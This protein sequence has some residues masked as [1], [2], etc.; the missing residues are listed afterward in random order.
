MRKHLECCGCVV[1]LVDHAFTCMQCGLVHG[2]EETHAYLD[3]NENKHKIVR[4]SVYHRKY[5][6][7]NIIG[8]ICV[9]NPDL[10]IWRGQINKILEVFPEIEKVVPIVNGRRMRIIRLF[11]RLVLSIHHV[12]GLN[13]AHFHCQT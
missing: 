4:K 10:Q 2:Y 6:I 5:H 1:E 7:E 11:I 9:K 13:C 8:N 12:N 3:F